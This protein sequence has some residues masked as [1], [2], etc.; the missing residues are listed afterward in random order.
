MLSLS[1]KTCGL[2]VLLR[3]M[4]GKTAMKALPVAIREGL[5]GSPKTLVPKRNEP[6]P[7]G[8]FFDLYEFE[9]NLQRAKDAFGEGQT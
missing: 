7:C 2:K 3:K 9:A 5:V 6:H 1:S 8:L 4:S